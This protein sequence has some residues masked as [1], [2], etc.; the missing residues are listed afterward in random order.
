M[1]VITLARKPLEGTVAETALKHSTGSLN[2]D[3]S[4]IPASN[5]P[6]R[7]IDPKETA[8]SV[9]VGRMK[10]GTGFDGGSKAVG[11][12]NLGRWPPNV[13]FQHRDGCRKDRDRWLC[14]P[15]CPVEALGS[16]R[17]FFKQ[18]GGEPMEG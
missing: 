12:T 15:G 13:I 3:S 18:V 17:R 5:R 4:R 9:F 14:E 1:R 2:I 7:V 16:A 8:S 11:S 6:L 10:P